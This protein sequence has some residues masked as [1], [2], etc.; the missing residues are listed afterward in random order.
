MLLPKSSPLQNDISYNGN[1]DQDQ[2]SDNG[3]R[4]YGVKQKVFVSIWNETT[5]T[6]SDDEVHSCKEKHHAQGHDERINLKLGNS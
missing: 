4:V 1:D 5:R 3:K 2:D 6:W